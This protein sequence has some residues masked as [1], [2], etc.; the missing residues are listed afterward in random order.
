MSSLR[1][2][3]GKGLG[4]MP[5]EAVV[6]GFNFFVPPPIDARSHT[7]PVGM[8]W[9][10]DGYFSSKTIGQWSDCITSGRMSTPAMRSFMLSVTIW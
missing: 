5:I 4:S 10:A 8:T 6:L 9:E 1:W 2:H 7:C 3:V